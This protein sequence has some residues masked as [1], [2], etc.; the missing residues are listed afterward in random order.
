MK[1]F[2]VPSILLAAALTMAPGYGR[3]VT[4]IQVDRLIA[5]YEESMEPHEFYAWMTTKMNSDSS[6]NEIVDRTDSRVL[7]R[8]DWGVTAIRTNQNVVWIRDSIDGSHFMA[9]FFPP[10]HVTFGDREF[11]RTHL[12]GGTLLVRADGMEVHASLYKDGSVLWAFVHPDGRVFRRT[13]NAD[14]TYDYASQP[15]R[16]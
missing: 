12:E 1:R 13:T 7:K 11:E 2:F 8:D 9:S 16:N 4:E 3:P 5:Q 15:K 6:W 14:G 10:G